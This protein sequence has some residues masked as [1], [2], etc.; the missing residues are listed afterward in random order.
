M[1]SFF[2]L[3]HFRELGLQELQKYF[4]SFFGSNEN[5]KICFRDLLAFKR[6]KSNCDIIPKATE[7]GQQNKA[8]SCVKGYSVLALLHA[9]KTFAGLLRNCTLLLSFRKF[10]F[11]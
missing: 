4:R 8:E 1:H 2:D 11:L 6:G 9:K 10:Y 5:F 3:I 7:M